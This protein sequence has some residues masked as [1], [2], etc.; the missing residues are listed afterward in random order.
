[1]PSRFLTG[2]IAPCR[3]VNV[4][5]RQ[6]TQGFFTLTYTVRRGAKV[7][8]D[9]LGIYTYAMPQ[10]SNEFKLLDRNLR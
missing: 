8:C 2:H 9:V 1:M 7:V 6:A 10:S 3:K 4:V 5:V